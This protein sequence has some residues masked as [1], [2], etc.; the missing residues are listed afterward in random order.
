MESELLIA[1]LKNGFADEHG[2][3]SEFRIA[4]RIRM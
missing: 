2:L 4:G 3:Y 1:E